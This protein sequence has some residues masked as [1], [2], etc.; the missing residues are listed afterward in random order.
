MIIKQ[1]K[2]AILVFLVTTI[3]VPGQD[4]VTPG[5]VKDKIIYEV[6]LR[7]FTPSGSLKEFRTHLPRLKELGAGILWLMPIHPI[8]EKNRKGTLGSY[9]AVK[10]YKDIDP[11]YG[12]KE[13]FKE[14]VKEVHDM[15]MY[16]IID[17]VANHTAWDHPWTSTNPD[18]YTKNEKG[19]FI[20]PV[21]D[22]QDVIDLNYDNKQLWHAMT[23]AL[24]YWVKEFNIDG[25]RCD[26]AGMVPQTFW[27]SARASLDSIKPVFMLAEWDT[28]EVHTAFNMSYGWKMYSKFNEIHAGKAGREDLYKT[29]FDHIKSLPKDGIIMQ[30]TSNHDE[31]SWNGTE[32]ERLGEAAPTFAALTFLLPGM[33]LIYSGQE[34]SLDKRLSFFEKDE[35]IWRQTKMTELYRTLSRLKKVNPALYNG[36]YGGELVRLDENLDGKVIAFVRDSNPN[37]VLACFNLSGEEKTI[38]LDL[39][40]YSG[41]YEEAFSGTVKDFDGRVSIKLS[42]YGYA[43][44]SKK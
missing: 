18:F 41:K 2:I 29:L 16:V 44:Y 27:E 43:I 6:N 11:L 42:P 30:F 9:Y 26:V 7:Q 33:P 25:Y 32:F 17:W 39:T 31:N 22:W 13:E 12:S 3:I 23:D 20:P 40:K 1:L 4:L 24:K 38:E 5:W 19:E 15:G 35:I 34:A 36:M 28:P 10:D 37:N 8:G 21:A 14:F